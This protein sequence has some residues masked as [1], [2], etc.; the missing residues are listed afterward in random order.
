MKFLILKVTCM[1]K[2]NT[3]EIY[4]FYNLLSVTVDKPSNID[5]SKVRITLK[6]H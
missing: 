5:M 2:S 4:V 6:Y 1:R 3:L